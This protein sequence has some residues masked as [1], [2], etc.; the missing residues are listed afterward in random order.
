M[1]HTVSLR[2]CSL[3]EGAVF[4]SIVYIGGA[5]PN[6]DSYMLK[7]MIKSQ[8]CWWSW[9]HEMGATIM[10]AMLDRL[11][12]QQRVERMHHSHQQDTE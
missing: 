10:M 7:F 4:K 3:S 11:A 8:R 6:P 2:L 1:V 9:W 12:M 5:N